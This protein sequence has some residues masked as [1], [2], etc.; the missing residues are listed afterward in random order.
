MDFPTRILTT[1][2]DQLAMYAGRLLLQA[3]RDIPANEELGID[4]YKVSRESVKQ[5][6]P[7]Q[8]GGDFYKRYYRFKKRA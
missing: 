6:R 1:D 5:Q 7:S 3:F 4:R 8:A 2:L